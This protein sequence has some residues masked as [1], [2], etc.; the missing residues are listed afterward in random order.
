[1]AGVHLGHVLSGAL[2]AGKCSETESCLGLPC[3]AFR[4][5]GGG[6]GESSPRGLG[7]RGARADRKGWRKPGWGCGATGATAASLRRRESRVARGAPQPRLP[8]RNPD[9]PGARRGGCRRVYTRL[10][11]GR[12]ARGPPRPRRCRPRPWPRWTRSRSPRSRR[13]APRGGRQAGRP[14]GPSSASTCPRSPA[15]C[16]AGRASPSPP[17]RRGGAAPTAGAAASGT[18]SGA[19]SPLAPGLPPT[20]ARRA[21]AERRREQAAWDRP[22]ARPPGGAAES[23]SPFQARRSGAES[24][25][26]H[27]RP[28][29][30]V[31]PPAAP[32]PRFGPQGR[33]QWGAQWLASRKRRGGGR[34]RGQGIDRKGARG[35]LVL[36]WAAWAR[37][38]EQGVGIPGER[39]RACWGGQV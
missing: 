1:M 33:I 14:A 31:H 5:L 34:S 10:P 26:L 37:R 15:A 38:G 32:R 8:A 20:G 30:P 35:V 18:S 25:R 36:A 22:A 2:G 3:S 27:P 4:G 24:R 39:I 29:L 6:V 28:A 19:S 23:P 12:A 7:L 21:H 16:G 11:G 17:P 9:R 13:S